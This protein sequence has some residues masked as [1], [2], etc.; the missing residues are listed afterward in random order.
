MLDL[1]Q[2]STLVVLALLSTVLFIHF[3]RRSRI[4]SSFSKIYKTSALAQLLSVIIWIS[5]IYVTFRNL[6]WWKAIID[7]II[8]F[9]VANLFSL[10]ISKFLSNKLLFYIS[11][12]GMLVSNLLLFINVF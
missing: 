3:D 8:A 6:I 7:L 10:L 2:D 9:V 11:I 5:I 12:V 4:N 1:H